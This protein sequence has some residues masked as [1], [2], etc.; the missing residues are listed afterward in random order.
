MAGR[1]AVKVSRR[2]R[3]RAARLA[4][5]AARFDPALEGKRRTAVALDRLSPSR[6]TVMHGVPWPGRRGTKIDHVVIGAPG[7][8]VIQAL[9]WFGA[10]HICEEV[11]Q[12]EGRSLASAEEAAWAVAQLTP[13]V[14]LRLV[15]PVICLVRD[16]PV[17]GQ[18]DDVLIFSCANLAEELDARVHEMSLEQLRVAPMHLRAHVLDS[19]AA[20]VP[21][22]P[23]KALAPRRVKP[24][25]RRLLP[26]REEAWRKGPKRHGLVL[27]LLTTV[28]AAFVFIAA[29]NAV[30]AGAQAFGDAV[31][32]LLR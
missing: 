10:T 29:P 6:W 17:V 19:H 1:S 14:P 11:L 7:I 12:R 22:A 24:Q 2:Q 4:E 30:I 18:V 32:G 8:F 9:D 5:S 25:R 3:R 21:A 13:S 26:P 31:A 20:I 15:H 23:P 16:K 28:S 27:P